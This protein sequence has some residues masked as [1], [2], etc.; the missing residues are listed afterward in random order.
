KQTHDCSSAATGSSLFDFNGD[1]NVEVAYADEFHLHVYDGKTG[2]EEYTICNTNG[3]LEENPVVADVDGDGQA[4]LIVVS[5][6]YAETCPDPDTLGT[7]NDPKESGIR[8]YESKTGS[9]VQTRRVWN[10]HGYHITNVNEDGTIPK[11]EANN[12]T[13]PGL[14]NF[15]QNKQPGNEFAAPDAI[16]SLAPRCSGGS[17]IVATVRNI[18]EAALPAGVVVGFYQGT[19]GA[20][21]LLGRMSTTT[22]LYPA[23]SED[24]V[25]TGK[26]AT[27]TMYAVVD[28]GSPAHA[29]HECRG[30][31][32]T[33]AVVSAACAGP[34]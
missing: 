14:N 9:W 33:S 15:R 8:I 28:D 22:I 30:D 5:N 23:E 6:A 32:D 2:N 18:G 12:W 24:L 27:G 4:D 20:G 1:G 10:Q 25:L 16:V 26:P 11:I 7:G 17:G 21:T 19:P 31:N 3:T 34:R 29:W 13:S